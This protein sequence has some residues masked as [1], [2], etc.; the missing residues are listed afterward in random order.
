[1]IIDMDIASFVSCDGRC[2][3]ER[4]L[5]CYY[6]LALGDLHLLASEGE[7]DDLVL[8]LGLAFSVLLGYVVCSGLA[9]VVLVS[10]SNTSPYRWS[11]CGWVIGVFRRECWYG[12]DGQKYWLRW[13]GM[14]NMGW[15]TWMRR[16][17]GRDWI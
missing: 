2:V 8:L 13:D 3:S 5:L 12:Q 10:Y 6:D 9:C 17:H 14:R 15:A 16:W 4:V 11:C 1:M 7:K